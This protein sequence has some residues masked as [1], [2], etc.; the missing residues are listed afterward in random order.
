MQS[1]YIATRTAKALEAKAL[2]KE[3]LEYMTHRTTH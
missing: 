1:S 3:A 2:E